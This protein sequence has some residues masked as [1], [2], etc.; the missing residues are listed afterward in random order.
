MMMFSA[1]NWPTLNNTQKG[2]VKVNTKVIVT[3]D[4]ERAKEIR[5]KLKL[6]NGYCPCRLLKT[7]DNKC[8]CREFKEQIA[9]GEL[10]S[11]HC[12]LYIVV[13]SDFLQV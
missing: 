8:I 13:E 2:F 10:G 7:E 6:N 5:E 4:A 1:L 3:S 11:C 12:G 9:R